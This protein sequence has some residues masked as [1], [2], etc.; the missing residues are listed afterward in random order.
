MLKKP[1]A[2]WPL[3]LLLA[4]TKF[5]LPL[6]LQDPIFELQRDEY[7][8]YQ[9]GQ[10]LALGYMENPPFISYLAMISSWFGGREAWVKIWPSLF[11]AAT[12]VA[13]L[14]DSSR[15]GREIVCA[16]YCRT[17]Y[18]YRR[19]FKNALFVSTQYPGYLLLD[20][21]YLFHYSLHQ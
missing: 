9:Q 1:E 8:Y 2:Y 15:T 5:I 6:F 10:H 11:G 18:Y 21:K 12:V 13:Y 3:I 20:I 17:Q 19:L 14:P 7:L 16:I 4:I